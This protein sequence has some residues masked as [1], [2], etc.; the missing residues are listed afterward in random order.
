[1]DPQW[2]RNQVSK[3]L[4]AQEIAIL[5]ASGAGTVAESEKSTGKRYSEPKR[6][7]EINKLLSAF[8]EGRPG[9]E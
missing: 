6:Q 5:I 2:L 4:T 7:R 1:M 8:S 9:V 3:G